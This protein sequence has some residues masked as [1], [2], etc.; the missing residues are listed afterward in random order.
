M[1]LRLLALVILSLGSAAAEKRIALTF[2]DAPRGDGPLY[3][4]AERTEVL[5]AALDD[6]ETGP[7]GMFVTT[8]GMEERD[9]GTARVAAYDDAGHLIANHS[10]RHL[11]ASRTDPEEY[12]ADL[13]QAHGYIKG[14]TNY[15]PWYRFPFLDEG[16]QGRNTERQDLYR[17]ALAER[18]LFSAYVTVDTYDWHVAD[19]WR[20]AVKDGKT[21]NL[22]AVR[23]VYVAMIVDA[24]EHYA[25]QAEAFLGRQPAHVLLLHENDPAAAFVG[26]AVEALREAGWTIISPDEAYAD[27]M[28][29][30]LP[31]TTFS[32][33][34]RVAALTMDAGGRG[35][36]TFDHWSASR[37][38][39]ASRL[40]EAGAFED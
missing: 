19:L 31:V 8:R 38:G 28:A 33:M 26:D 2:D 11:W 10:H 6:A 27:P 21:I 4:G 39:I 25:D 34:G 22:D 9:G 23:S 3:S 7:V 37:E 15:R 36:E 32:G 12:L 24:A 17:Q 40:A 1:L 20:R 13:D 30:Q 14:F 18:G 5:I 16:G 29:E 35:G